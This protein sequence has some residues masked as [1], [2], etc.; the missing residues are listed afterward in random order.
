MKAYSKDVLAVLHKHLI[1]PTNVNIAGT[2]TLESDG[3]AT[4]VKVTLE[5]N[6]HLS[7]EDAKALADGCEAEAL[8][9]E[10]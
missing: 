5:V 9:D 10:P 8:D 3:D 2:V 6:A 4:S 1:E 7:A